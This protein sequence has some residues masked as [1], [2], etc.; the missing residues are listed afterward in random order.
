MKLRYSLDRDIH[1]I[2]CGC[3]FDVICDVIWRFEIDFLGIE[4]NMNTKK[5]HG[6][7]TFHNHQNQAAIQRAKATEIP[8]RTA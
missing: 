8:P 3:F 2:S 7:M 5:R 4:Q 1:I 6:W